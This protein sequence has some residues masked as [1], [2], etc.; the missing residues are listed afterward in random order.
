MGYSIKTIL[1]K[2][3]SRINKA[4]TST[5]RTRNP[6]HASTD[7]GAPAEETQITNEYHKTCKSTVLS[8]S[9]QINHQYCYLVTLLSKEKR[10]QSKETDSTTNGFYGVFPT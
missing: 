6:H 2:N 5:I 3:S 7:P 9:F 1:Q 4:Y 10:R 8:A